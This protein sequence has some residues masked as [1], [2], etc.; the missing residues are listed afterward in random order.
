MFDQVRPVLVFSSVRTA[1]RS[2]LSARLSGGG[3]QVILR[4]SAQ[5]RTRL[6]RQRDD[7]D[8]A[9]MAIEDCLQQQL[10][11]HRG[12]A[13]FAAEIGADL[14]QRTRGPVEQWSGWAAAVAVG[15]VPQ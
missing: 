5:Q 7:L 2:P 10:P 4:A 13:N 8:A 6:V 11:G 1:Q 15:P 12:F 9:R 14:P 3:D